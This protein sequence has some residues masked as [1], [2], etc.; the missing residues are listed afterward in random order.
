MALRE[1]CLPLQIHCGPRGF[2]HQ[3]CTD[4]LQ[5][6]Q[7]AVRR[8]HIQ[9]PDR[10]LGCPPFESSG[11][12]SYRGAMKAAANYAFANRQ[13]LAHLARGSLE[14]VLA[15]RVPNTHLRQV[16]DIAHNMAKVETH[17][18]EGRQVQGCVHH[19]GE[20]RAF[21]PG[22]HQVPEEYRALGQP[23][24]VPGSLGTASWALLGTEAG[25][26]LS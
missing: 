9:L 18:I 4:C 3:V 13:V 15:G 12:P 19:K 25:M 23:V 6:L 2:G 22:A 11:G 21:G 26:A 1:G 14:R 10:V 8:Y 5:D 24:L 17:H 16:Y 7:S 20:L